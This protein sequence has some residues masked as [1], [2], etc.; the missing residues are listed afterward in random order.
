MKLER[1]EAFTQEIFCVETHEECVESKAPK[2]EDRKWRT[3]VFRL[4]GGEKW[5]TGK[6][7]TKFCEKSDGLKWRSEYGGRKQTNECNESY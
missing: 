5:R 6:Y 3:S 2:M 4:S 7:R 1:E